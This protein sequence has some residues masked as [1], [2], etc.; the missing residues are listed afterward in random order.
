MN[1]NGNKLRA[2]K[3]AH[4]GNC[5]SPWSNPGFILVN[6]GLM[7]VLAILC[8]TIHFFPGKF[9]LLTWFILYFST[10]TSLS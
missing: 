3:A 4:K 5:S 7:F 8:M 6:M 9:S 10:L 1:S 2:D